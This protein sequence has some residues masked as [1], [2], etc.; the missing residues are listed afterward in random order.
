MRSYL[1]AGDVLA[2]SRVHA[3]PVAH[4]DEQRDPH[5][6]AGLERGRLVAAAARRVAAQS[7]LGLGHGHLDGARHLDLGRA[8]VDVENVHLLR[9]EH[10]LELVADLRKRDRELL[11]G[12]GVHEVGVRAVVVEVLELAGLGAHR[13]ELLARPEGLVDDVAVGGALELGADER[14]ALAG[15][16]VL[17]LDDLEDRPVHVDVSPVL[18]LIG[19]DHG[20]K[21]SGA[22]GAQP[23]RNCTLYDT[24]PAAARAPLA[25]R[26]SARS[27][28]NQT[29]VPA[30]V[31]IPQRSESSST[32]C[33][34]QCPSVGCRF[35]RPSGLKPS[36]PSPTET[37]THL[38]VIETASANRSPASAPACWTLLVISSVVRSAP[39]SR[40]AGTSSPA[41]RSSSRRAAAG[42]SGSRTI[43]RCSSRDGAAMKCTRE[44]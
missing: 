39:M 1:G 6:H 23:E 29:D 37:R 44:A 12:L 11:V 24:E 35:T 34:P 40:S 17:E 18:E 41:I 31:V 14:A 28:S 21:A 10:P 22:D 43:W 42:A 19:A 32:S 36:P 15:L 27:S 4:V 38:S 7:G 9:L 33:S 16:H 26:L 8:A 5:V 20:C 2:R 30:S 3:H 13:A 25:L